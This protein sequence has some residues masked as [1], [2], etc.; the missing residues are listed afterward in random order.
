MNRENTMASS[1][2]PA[3]LALQALHDGKLAGSWTL[4]E[5]RSRIRLR[6]TA[7]WGLVPIKGVFRQ[8]SGEGVITAKGEASGTVTV[9]AGSIDTKNARRDGHL[10][11]AAFLD[12]DDHPDIVCTVDRVEP[13]GQ[14][15][16]L[17]LTGSLTIRGRTRQVSFDAQVTGL[18]DDELQLD[19][20]VLID[21][22][23]FGL[24][25]SP[26]GMA[27]MSNTIA[28]HAVFTRQEALTPAGD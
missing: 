19:G 4:D 5:R 15:L 1:A 6:T 25:W 11:S 18:G 20:E 14:G 9:T 27:A 24:T 21:R 10:R 8:V 17:T 12:V 22:A 16:T 26:L 23:D 3:V 13:A 28:V 7:I 2:Q